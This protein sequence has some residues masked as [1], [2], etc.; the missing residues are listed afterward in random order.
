MISRTQLSA[1]LADVRTTAQL[2]TESLWLSGE[3]S[4]SRTKGL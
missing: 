1:L 2:A 4:E 3:A